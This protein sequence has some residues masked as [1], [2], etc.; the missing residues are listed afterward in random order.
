MCAAWH[1]MTHYCEKHQPRGSAPLL[2]L[3]CTPDV[4]VS[5]TG[6]FP[7]SCVHIA[8]CCPC[9]CFP[10]PATQ[11][12]HVHSPK[13]VIPIEILASLEIHR[14]SAV[15]EILHGLRAVVAVTCLFTGEPHVVALPWHLGL[16]LRFC[17]AKSAPGPCLWRSQS[18]ASWVIVGGGV[19]TMTKA[20]TA[21]HISYRSP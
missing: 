18:Y 15:V 20:V 4:I 6:P 5:R 9:Q 19:V 2:N 13:E 11:S 10:P 17:N 3:Y 1:V 7:V 12:T 8:L 21:F 14:V 16:D